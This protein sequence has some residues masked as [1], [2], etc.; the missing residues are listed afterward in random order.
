[1]AA[2]WSIEQTTEA[3]GLADGRILGGAD[4]TPS[5]L[6]TV[7]DEDPAQTT[8]DALL[9]AADDPDDLAN[10]EDV[11][12]S[13]PDRWPA[14]AHV[15]VKLARSRAALRRETDPGHVSLVIPLYCEHRRL[16]RPDEDPLGEDFLSRKLAQLEWLFGDS[17]QQ[18]YDVWLV[19]DGCPHGSGEL[20]R[21]HLARHHP[22]APARVLFLEEAIRA[23]RGGTGS[24][25][26][27]RDS[28]KGGAVEYGMWVA[29]QQRH[30]RHVVAYTDAD[31]STHLGQL[32]LLLEPIWQ[33]G[34]EVAAGSRR[35]RRS[36]T[37]KSGGRSDRGLLFIYLW[38]RLLPELRYLVDTQCGFK[39]FRAYRV[40]ELVSGA[41]EKG[42]AFDIELLLRA[43]QS[44][45]RSIEAVP[46]AWIDSE[47]ASTTTACSPY[48]TMLR[49]VVRLYRAGSRGDAAADRIAHRIETLDETGWG[50][51]LE[52]VPSEITQTDPTRFTGMFPA[53]D[54]AVLEALH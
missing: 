27:T 18:G 17:P 31:L 9:D 16:R 24:L 46:V 47:A 41:I 32:G 28:R 38:Q 13:S 49:S 12:S 43:E 54:G 23:H 26:D 48:L 6:A 1:M 14:Q 3:V 2:E 37:V 11:L 53:C 8:A 19:D 15:A 7:D 39:A 44:H 22:D 35:E 4:T 45:R 21:E 20:A 34:R 52:N 29:S 5:H 40:P 42:F 30:P 25:H 36:F 33:R 50:R 10:L 51:V